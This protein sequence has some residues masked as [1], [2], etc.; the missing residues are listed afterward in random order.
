MLSRAIN[1]WRRKSENRIKDVEN[2]RRVLWRR[3][4]EKYTSPYPTYSTRTRNSDIADNHNGKQKLYG[5]IAPR[6]TSRL[7][8]TLQDY[9]QRN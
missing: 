3:R 1:G 4:L 8:R 9:A 6:C 2:Y 5:H 7:M